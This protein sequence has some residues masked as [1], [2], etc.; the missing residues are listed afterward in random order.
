MKFHKLDELPTLKNGTLLL[1]L[2][3]PGNVGQLVGDLL[4]YNFKGK[5]LGYYENDHIIPF[6]SASPY[7]EKDSSLHFAAELYQLKDKPS[8]FVLLIRTGVTSSKALYLDLYAYLNKDE[9]ITNSIN[10]SLLVTS[11]SQSMSVEPQV[12]MGQIQLLTDD[13]IVNPVPGLYMTPLTKDH[14][15]TQIHGLTRRLIQYKDTLKSHKLQSMIMLVHEGN[16]I[17][18]A[19]AFLQALLIALSHDFLGRVAVPSSWS[20]LIK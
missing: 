5:R 1:C 12:A 3:S 13:I 16:N 11:G 14:M 10:S 2:P 8:L 7:D 20:S 19:M 9:F 18:H 15:G 17:P 4:I 6:V